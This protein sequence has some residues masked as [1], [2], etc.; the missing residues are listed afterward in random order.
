MGRRRMVFLLCLRYTYGSGGT[1][2]FTH[3]YILFFYWDHNFGSLKYFI[4]YR[5]FYYINI[6]ILYQGVHC[7][8]GNRFCDFLWL[9][10]TQ[11]SWPPVSYM[12]KTTQVYTLMNI[13]C[14]GDPIGFMVTKSWPG[15]KICDLFFIL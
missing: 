10:K 6:I 12:V 1:F 7:F 15:F 5:F 13:S 9:K 4:L 2:C 11:I 8:G 3:I 14:G